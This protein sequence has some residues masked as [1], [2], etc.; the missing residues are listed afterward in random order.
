MKRIVAIGLAALITL[1][2]A[3]C[4]PPTPGGGFN[5]PSATPAVPVAAATPPPPPPVKVLSPTPAAPASATP[6][7]WGSY[8]APDNSFTVDAPGL[9]QVA[10]QKVPGRTISHY[11]LQQGA[12]TYMV[13]SYPLVGDEAKA[14]PASHVKPFMDGAVG[15][16]TVKKRESITVGT[17]PGESAQLDM[18]SGARRFVQVVVTQ[19]CIYTLDASGMPSDWD[20]TAVTRFMKSFK[21]SGS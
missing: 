21:P 16:N 8:K 19:N 5:L 10:A 14:A 7:Q 2:A 15:Q 17:A 4:T 3:S 1:F 13:I 9:F 20:E 6:A 12:L 11:N 18:P